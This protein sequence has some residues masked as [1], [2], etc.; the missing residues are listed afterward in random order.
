MCISHFPSAFNG[1]FLGIVLKWAARSWGVP[2]KKHSD[3]AGSVKG[4]NTMGETG[5][6][7]LSEKAKGYFE[8]GFN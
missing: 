4:E 7:V 5:G 2:L 3:E 8:K 6:K 1:L